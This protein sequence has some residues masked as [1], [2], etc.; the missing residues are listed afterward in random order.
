MLG[1]IEGR[2]RGWQR[3]RWLDG[4][5]NSTD[6]GLGGLPGVGDGQGGLAWCDSWGHKSWTW[7]CDWTESLKYLLRNIFLLY[8]ICKWLLSKTNLL[9]FLN[10]FSLSNSIVVARNTENLY[11]T[12]L[13]ISAFQ[14]QHIPVNSYLTNMVLLSCPL[15]GILKEEKRTNFFFYLALS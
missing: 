14:N 12:K 7:L 15:A 2:R 10:I 13:E 8:H 11:Q 3:M 4:I 5:T 1:K 9:N 6:L